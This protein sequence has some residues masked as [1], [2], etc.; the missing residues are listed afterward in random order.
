MTR[1]LTLVL[2]A[3]VALVL[4]FGA[5]WWLAARDASQRADIDRLRDDAATQER[6]DDAQNDSRACGD[7][8]LDRLRCTT[9]E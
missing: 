5:G 8:W 7:G 1:T 6:I 2:V 3:A 9:D 4:V